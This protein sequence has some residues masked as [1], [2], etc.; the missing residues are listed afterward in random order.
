MDVGVIVVAS[1]SGRSS[2]Q[3]ITIL[4]YTILY[5]TIHIK[6]REAQKTP[7]HDTCQQ[8]F[9][10]GTAC[11]ASAMIWPPTLPCKV[12]GT[13]TAALSVVEE[14]VLVCEDVLVTEM[15]QMSRSEILGKHSQPTTHGKHWKT[16]RLQPFFSN[17]LAKL[18]S[19]IFSLRFDRGSA[20]KLDRSTEFNL[21]VA[22]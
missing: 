15:P 21:L 7:T 1:P 18:I 16:L 19:H 10:H 2:D 3:V 11:N 8:H 17:I 13:T 14:V 22:F 5:Y 9:F 6:A 4:Y 12:S 20:G